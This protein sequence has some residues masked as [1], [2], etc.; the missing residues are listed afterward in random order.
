M[1]VEGGDDLLALVPQADLRQEGGAVANLDLQPLEQQLDLGLGQDLGAL[2]QE[3][4]RQ[5]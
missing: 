5:V 3:A 1:V 2:L 4:G